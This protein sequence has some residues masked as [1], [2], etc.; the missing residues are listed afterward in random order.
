M[1][2][3]KYHEQKL[4]KKVDFF[5]WKNDNNLREVKVMRRY[6]VQDRDDLKMYNKV[7][8]QL[9]KVVIRLR[10]LPK[11][12]KFRIKQTKILLKK[13]FEMGL[14]SGVCNLKDVEDKVGISA[15]CRRRLPVVMFRNKYCETVKE[16]VTFLEQSQVRVGTEVVNNPAYIV[17]RSMEDHISWVDGSKIKRKINE[18]KGE[19]DDYD[20]NC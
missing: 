1:R 4:L 6:Y 13:L 8:G 15:F 9:R 20:E 12:D 16:A 14:I 3:L 19:V 11:D 17:T 18:Y 2:E 5:D 7:V 10:A